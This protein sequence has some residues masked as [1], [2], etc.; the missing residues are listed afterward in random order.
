MNDIPAEDV[1]DAELV[2]F[3]HDE[4][5]PAA[6]AQ[7]QA[8]LRVDAALRARLAVFATVDTAVL[9]ALDAPLRTRAAVPHGWWRPAFAAAAALVVVTLLLWR[10]EAAAARN[11]FVELRVAPRGGASH[12]LFTE[13]ALE[14]RWRNRLAAERGKGLAIVPA[15]A[16]DPLSALAEAHA[17]DAERNAFVPLVVRAN[18][19]APDGKQHAAWLKPRS[20]PV[21]ITDREVVQ[22]VLLSD[23]EWQTTDAAPYYGG[24][25]G[26]GEWVGDFQWAYR[27]T[28]YHET[29]RW[30]PDQPGEW[31]IELRVE[32]VPPLGD[33]RAPANPWP[34]FAEPLVVTTAIVLTGATSE[35]GAMHD[36]MQARLVLSTGCKDPG[37]APMA[38][39]LRNSSGRSRKYNV[40]GTTIAKIPQP[41]HFTLCTGSREAPDEWVQPGGVGVIT[42]MEDLMRVHPD[43]TTRTLVVCPDYWRRDGKRLGELAG[44]HAVFVRFHSE[45][46]VWLANDNELWMGK[47]DTGNVTLH[48]PPAPK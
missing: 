18:L 7:L 41:F 27:A 2:A 1:M 26:V 44:E 35:W 40:T 13:V 11:D 12:P 29:P 4:L 9:D 25:P 32:C 28:P 46:S 10:S 43:N 48:V 47:I 14:L 45:P 21:A 8:R 30:L 23:F 24:R 36:G 22:K 19:T 5:E 34:T 16:G 17:A 3:A 20:A 6:R 38:V 42:A 37:R 15:G 31:R 33:K 39:Q